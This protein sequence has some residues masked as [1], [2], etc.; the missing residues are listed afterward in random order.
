MR[1]FLE[2][3]SGLRI[4]TFSKRTSFSSL[5]MIK[6]RSIGVSL[7]FVILHT[8]FLKKVIRDITSLICID[9]VGSTEESMTYKPFML[10]LDSF[11]LMDIETAKL[12]SL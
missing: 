9:F 11:G 12:I 8:S 2:Q 1:A 7:S 5:F 6:S 3:N 10:Y 4:L